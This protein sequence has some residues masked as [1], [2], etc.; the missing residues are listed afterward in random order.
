[1]TQDEK[2]FEKFLKWAKESKKLS[3]WMTNN[4]QHFAKKMF[5]LFYD[6]PSFEKQIATTGTKINVF[7]LI[8][9]YVKDKAQ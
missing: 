8:E 3:A 6:Y 5:E 2:E 4:Q 9:E 1:M 7:Q